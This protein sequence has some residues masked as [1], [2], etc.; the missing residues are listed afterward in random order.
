MSEVV[1]IIT[2][3]DRILIGGESKQRVVAEDK[4]VSVVTKH[5]QG[6]ARDVVNRIPVTTAT[7]TVTESMLISGINVIGVNFNGAVT[8][9]IP[10]S[11]DSRKLI[12]VK[13][14]SDTAATNNITILIAN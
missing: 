3:N 13:D 8:I 1:E 9:T 2:T 11:V 6:P 4:E 10:S 7:F 5:E 14:E 12:Y